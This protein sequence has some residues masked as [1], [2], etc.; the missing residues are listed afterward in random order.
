M[1]E[2]TKAAAPAKMTT[3]NPEKLLIK[4]SLY[5]T[6]LQGIIVACHAQIIGLICGVIAVMEV[7]V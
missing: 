4:Y 3:A 7:L 5:A 1:P 2:T 6:N